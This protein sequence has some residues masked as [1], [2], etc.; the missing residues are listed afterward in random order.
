MPAKLLSQRMKLVYS[1]NIYH[2]MW[3]PRNP[4]QQLT[5]KWS[6]IDRHNRIWES[7]NYLFMIEPTIQD[8]ITSLLL[9][10]LGISQSLRQRTLPKYTGKYEFKA[11]T[12]TFKESCEVCK[13]DVRMG[14]RTC[15]GIFISTTWWLAQTPSKKREN[16]AQSYAAACG[17]GLVFASGTGNQTKCWNSYKS[18][19]GN[20]Y[21]HLTSTRKAE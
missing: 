18:I 16:S 2:I 11:T 9:R 17:V 8:S 21:T 4:A 20:Q 1:H 3:S 10:W 14:Q 6:S 13:S 12:Q 19:G 5:Y 15:K 7:L